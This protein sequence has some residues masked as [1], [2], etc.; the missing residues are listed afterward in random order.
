MKYTILLFFSCLLAF[1]SK[2]QDSTIALSQFEI[3]T[4]QANRILKT[5]LKELVG[6][7]SRLV[8]VFKTTDLI[9]GTSMHAV[10]IGYLNALDMPDLINPQALYF[11]L[12]ELDSIINV[13]TYFLMETEKPK[14]TSDVR[15]SYTTTNDIVLSCSYSRGNGSWRF[16]FGKTYKYLRV[17]VPGSTATYHNKK[18]I[19]QLIEDLKTAKGTSM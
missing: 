1:N 7:D 13:L 12:N 3:F 17:L 15:L 16:D 18:R 19:I 4:G 9:S 5:E 14:P 10:Q 2:S 6:Q 11:D 8:T